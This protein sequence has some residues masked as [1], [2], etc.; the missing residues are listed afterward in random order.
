MSNAHVRF[1]RPLPPGK[2]EYVCICQT[3][4]SHEAN[5]MFALIRQRKGES[6]DLDRSRIV[7]ASGSYRPPCV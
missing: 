5:F 2:C 6:V 1:A 4:Q 7:G 3:W